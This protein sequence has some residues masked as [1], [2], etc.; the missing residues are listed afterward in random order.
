[1][2]KGFSPVAGILLIERMVAIQGSE[3][4]HNCFSPVAG[5]LLIESSAIYIVN[6]YLACF[7]PVAGILL[8]ESYPFCIGYVSSFN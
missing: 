1:M 8:I 6:C 4:S 2:K 5:I 3:W 7:S